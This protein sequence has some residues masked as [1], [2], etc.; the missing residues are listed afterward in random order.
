MP[1]PHGGRT[2]LC[3][4]CMLTLAGGRVGGPLSESGDVRITHDA[5]AANQLVAAV[6]AESARAAVRVDG[7]RAVT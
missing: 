5:E 7:R 1:R 3:S 4:W 6:T 2:V